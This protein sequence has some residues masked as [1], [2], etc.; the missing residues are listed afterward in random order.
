MSATTQSPVPHSLVED[1]LAL[2]MGSLF[3]ALG[4]MLLKAAGLSFG[5]LAGLALI[6]DA[7]FGLP[8]AP[9]FYALSLP[10]FVFGHLAFGR[11]Y[12]VKSLIATSSLA[13]LA[14]ILPHGV[15]ITHVDPPVAAVAA[16]LLIG[17]GMLALIRH[18]TG[19]GGIATLAVWLQKRFG[20]RAG[21]VQMGV[22]AAIVATALTVLD[23]E[24]VLLSVV[25]SVLMNLVIGLYHRPGR[26][27]G[28]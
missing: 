28:F 7:G 22:D 6:A 3:I 21:Y 4:L 11:V 1:G 2:L 17:M 19:V 9:V 10:F 20:L 24:A 26:Y 27:L 13:L 25:A 15:T 14:G 16:G 18:N 5:G 12:L 8:F 23:V